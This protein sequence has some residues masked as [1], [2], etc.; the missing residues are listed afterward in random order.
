MSFRIVLNSVITNSK[1]FLPLEK[2]IRQW[3]KG[4]KSEFSIRFSNNYLL[5]DNKKRRKEKNPFMDIHENYFSYFFV[6]SFQR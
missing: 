6:H 2:K 4:N 1:T 3:T 5:W